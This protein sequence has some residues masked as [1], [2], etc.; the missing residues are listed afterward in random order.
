MGSI[1]A[2]ARDTDISFTNST[3]AV[4]IFTAFPVRCN[5]KNLDKGFFLFCFFSSCAAVACLYMFVLHEW[6]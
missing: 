4:L 2:T 3:E 6:I 1:S 5:H